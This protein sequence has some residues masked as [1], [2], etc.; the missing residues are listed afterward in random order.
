MKKL[1]SR[2]NFSYIHEGAAKYAILFFHLQ[3]LFSIKIMGYIKYL[4]YLTTGVKGKIYFWKHENII[5]TNCN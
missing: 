5:T 2:C 4:R 1:A 3:H